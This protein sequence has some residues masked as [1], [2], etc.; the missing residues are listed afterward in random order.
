MLIADTNLARYSDDDDQPQ[1]G[2][3]AGGGGR[4]EVRPPE[5][6]QVEIYL[7]V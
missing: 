3:G 6:C 1:P 7:V 2:G 4:G 5:K